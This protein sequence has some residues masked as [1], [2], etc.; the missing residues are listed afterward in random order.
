METM[1]L[2]DQQSTR[3]AELPENYRVMGIDCGAPFVVRRPTGQLLRIEPNGRLTEATVEA[4][5]RL[6]ARPAAA[7]GRLAGG[8]QEATPYTSVMD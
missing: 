8:V 3:I 1:R 4:K 5:L 7:A 2:S 6:A